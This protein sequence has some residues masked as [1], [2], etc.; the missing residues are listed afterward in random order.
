MDYTNVH[1]YD[2]FSNFFVVV[3]F[4]DVV[5]I[6]AAIIDFVVVVVAGLLMDSAV[7]DFVVDYL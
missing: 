6:D 3:P 5:A 2:D 1:E 4:D 7:V